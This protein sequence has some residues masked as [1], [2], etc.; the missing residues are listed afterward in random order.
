[1]KS[2]GFS[3]YGINILFFVQFFSLGDLSD[4]KF[5]I[6]LSP[7]VLNECSRLYISNLNSDAII[8]VLIIHL[9]K[10]LKTVQT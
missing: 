10:L 1:M 9:K 4:T 2:K 3:S 5:V 6:Y 8:S 7:V